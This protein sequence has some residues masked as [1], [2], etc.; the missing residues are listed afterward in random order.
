MA[1]SRG[2]NSCQTP[3]VF[4]FNLELGVD[5]DLTLE[6]NAGSALSKASSLQ[7]ESSGLSDASTGLDREQS[8]HD[9]LADILGGLGGTLPRSARPSAPSSS[10]G[11][12]RHEFT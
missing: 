1:D 11:T 12:R 4:D 7:A 8:T 5:L 2:W 3:S 9:V 10:Q 6:C